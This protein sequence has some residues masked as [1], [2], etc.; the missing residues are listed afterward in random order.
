MREKHAPCLALL[1]L[2]LAL[3]AARADAGGDN[4]LVISASCGKAPAIGAQGLTG[5]W[6]CKTDWEL[7]IS[8][9]WRHAQVT[10]RAGMGEDEVIE[11]LDDAGIPFDTSSRSEVQVGSVRL[12]FGGESLQTFIGN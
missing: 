9:T 1:L 12:Q 2:A 4:G 6:R 8:N 7:R 11:M 5:P 3:P 10:L